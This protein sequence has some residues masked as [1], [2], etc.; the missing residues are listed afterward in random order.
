MPFRAEPDQS[1]NPQA[2]RH[3]RA[4]CR[5]LGLPH[6]V[7]HRNGS[8]AAAAACVALAA[9]ARN[10]TDTAAHGKNPAPSAEKQRELPPAPTEKQRV[11]P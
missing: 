9:T 1:R 7:R 5:V 3:W 11:R 6:R 2:A 4:A 8:L 10:D